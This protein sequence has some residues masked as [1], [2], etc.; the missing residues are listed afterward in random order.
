MYTV[1]D[2]DYESVAIQADIEA[3]D[4][5]AQHQSP[6]HSGQVRFTSL[7]F[8]SSIEHNHRTPDSSN[9]EVA[10]TMKSA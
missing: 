1:Q 3:A 5:V 10:L 4:R 6:H 7:T 2:S 9:D 8:C